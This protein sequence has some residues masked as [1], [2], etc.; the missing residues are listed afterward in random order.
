VGTGYHYL[1]D[2]AG[3]IASKQVETSQ[4][5]ASMTSYTHN[6][7]NQL[8][9]IGGSVGVKQVVV[10]G[11]TNEP[12]TVK[13][14]SS[15]ASIWKDAR[16]LEG[17]RFES[18]QDLAVGSNQLNIRA[19]DGSGNTS[20][21]TYSLSLAAATAAVPSYD[22]DG[23]LL[24][25]GIR[26]F[27]WDASS[28]L[29]KIAWGAGSDK[30]TEYRYNA[31]SQRSE[32]IEK[33]GTVETAHYYY[34]YEG[35]K[36]LYRYNG[37]ATAA[38]VDRLYVAQ[39]EQRKNGGLWVLYYYNRD[40]LGSIRE[41]MNINGTLAARYDYE[42]YGKR[43]VQYEASGYTCDLGFTGHIT[44]QSAVSGQSEI[45]LTHYRAYDPNFGKWLSADPIGEKGSLNLYRYVFNSPSNA[46][47]LL[48]LIDIVLNPKPYTAKGKIDRTGLAMFI[49]NAQDSLDK[50]TV[51]A[52]GNESSVADMR[53]GYP[54]INLTP[55]D[56]ADI[57]K[58]RNDFKNTKEVVLYSCRTGKG[59]NSFA[60]QLAKILKIPVWAPSDYLWAL[61]NGKYTV[62][63]ES[64]LGFTPGD[65]KMLKFP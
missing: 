16:L 54:G 47:D 57:I 56:L 12:A 17:N 52:H 36:L 38:N 26:T 44:Q 33:T 48:G 30:S 50:I 62:G 3:N 5:G 61:G 37:A 60:E 34:L 31:L 58:A 51:Y 39:G 28:R 49:C 35:S 8:T 22:A 14:K 7:V 65:G 32:Q 10:R 63:S 18:D 23:N 29:I 64:T 21:Y 11:Q 53:N 59:P 6:S 42:P 2:P 19:K 20:N 46:I 1:Y 13:V 45:V 41:V 24:T 25:D 43:I 9:G 55:Q 40:H 4:A 27:E 15:V